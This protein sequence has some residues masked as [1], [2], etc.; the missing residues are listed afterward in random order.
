MMGL[1][2]M[3][4][5]PDLPKVNGISDD[6]QLGLK[7]LPLP[8]TPDVTQTAP[9]VRLT[10]PQPESTDHAYLL[11][12]EEQSA[13][14]FELPS[15]GEIVIGRAP[16]ATLRLADPSASRHH[17]Q[18]TMHDGAALVCDLG[19]RN[20]TR[21]N[22]ER[23]E[24]ASALYHGDVVSV[25]SATL[26]FSRE[27]HRPTERPIL[28]LSQ[29][30]HRLHEELDRSLRY[31][32]PMPI[33]CLRFDERVDRSAVSAALTGQLRNMDVLAWSRSA[34][35]FLIL[36]ELNS[37][38]IADAALR[39]SAILSDRGIA[40]RTGYATYPSDGSDVDTLLAGA[41]AAATAARS[42]PPMT[43]AETA[44]TL[45]I[46]ERRIV[47]MDAAMVRLYALI[48][49]L[50]VTDLPA[51]IQGET[52]VGKELAATAFHHYSKRQGKAFISVNCAALPESLV[53]SELFGHERGAFTGAV[54]AKAGYLEAASGGTLFLD[55]IG[56]LPA[57]AQAKL[58][59]ALE[60]QRITRVGEVRE[61]AIDVRII[62]ATNRDLKVE[63][64][65]GRFRKDL[66]FRL[67][68]ARITLPPLRERRRELPV[69]ARSLLAQ[70]CTRLGRTAMEISPAA[71]LRIQGYSWPGNVRELKNAVDYVAATVEGE[72]VLPWHLD[73]QVPTEAAPAT[74]AASLP[75]PTKFRPIEEEIKALERQ[76]MM[77]ALAASG[78]VQTRAAELISMPVRTFTAKVKQYQLSPRKTST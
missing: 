15:N 19:S 72:L 68:G 45:C 55:E 77:E 8:K 63:S 14:P 3:A 30:R 26:I 36:P 67:N 73:E 75:L 17:A 25:C 57:G 9:P 35:L 29:L 1:L 49:K 22:G 24:A 56:E 34:E 27:A 46:G 59:R 39:L 11:V 31:Q 44:T 69:L 50:A 43:A 52:G 10:A 66:Y 12:I 78:G 38:E 61:R 33:L 60:T 32:R 40:C 47:L 64:E 7:P 76:R 28:T 6:G 2:A 13:L 48:E 62:A 4:S 16:D 5:K 42:G 54:T 71:M 21:I 23:I 53:E 37:D 20:G 18:I 70:A 41:Q 65:A 51:L 58:L 74:E